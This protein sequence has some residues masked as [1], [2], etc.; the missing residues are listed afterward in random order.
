MLIKGHLKKFVVKILFS[1]MLISFS[2]SDEPYSPI[3]FSPVNYNLNEMPYDNLS[4]YNF[5]EGE[6]KNLAPVYGVVPY[7]LISSLFTDYSIKN[8]FLWM[9][10]GVSA[11]YV[12][13]SSVFDFPIGT[14]LIKNFSYDN[15]LPDLISKNIETRLMIK[16]ESGWIFAD[17]IWNEEQTEASFSLDGSVVDISWLQD[18]V[19]K[20]ASYRIPSASECLTC[21]KISDGSIPNG[22]KPRNINKSLDYA[23]SSMNQLDKWLEM[24]YLN[25]YP[26]DIEAV[27]NWKDLSEPLEKRVRSYI[28]INCAHCHSDNTHC[29]YRPI[30]LSFEATEDLANMGVCLTPDTNL[31]NGTD[32]IINPG[33]INRSVL[34]FR[35]TSNEEQYRMPLI[36]RSIVHDEAITMIEEWIMSLDDNCN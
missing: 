8:R 16:K 10:D 7:E 26:Q 13:S 1:L 22:V 36:G 35:M 31:G 3:E 9:P 4:Q 24:G 5:F 30:R 2:C 27:A 23:T 11:N 33:N 6:M 18:G 32:F 25:S 20:N 34:H 17:Y 14:I 19:E 12:S 29:E 21:H 15:I 28:D